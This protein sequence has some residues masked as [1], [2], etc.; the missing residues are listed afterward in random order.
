[1]AKRLRREPLWC[2][3]VLAHARAEERAA[4]LMEEILGTAPVVY[5]E[6]G[7]DSIELSV[8]VEASRRP[9]RWEWSE[10]ARKLQALKGLAG[11]PA[12][13]RVALRDWRHSWKRHFKPLTI[14]GRLLIRPSWSKRRARP[15]QAV[16]VLDPG[17][18][19]GTG[20]HPTTAF[21]LH[22]IVR[23]RLAGKP[24]SLLDLG[25]GSGILAIAAAKL[26]YAPVRALD[27]DPDCIRV[28]RANARRNR[29]A[30]PLVIAAGDVTQLP[31]PPARRFGVVCANLLAPLLREQAHTIVAHVAPG[32]CLVVAGI[33]VNEFR[34]VDDRLR[35]L[36]AVRLR[37]RA[38]AT[39]MSAA[40]RFPA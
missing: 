31:L 14:G 30:H 24:Q 34:A 39:W 9:S 26:G 21:C 40:Y 7:S 5:S 12:W 23:N 36:H 29:V 16:V 18:S 4:S 33:L 1:M 20:Q 6:P 38:E 27:H 2:A 11:R 37:A 10:L 25:T 15:G 19:F 32:G 17:L 8:Y 3:R 35:D 13:R 22:E 28:A